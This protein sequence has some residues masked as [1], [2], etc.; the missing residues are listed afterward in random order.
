MSD[1]VVVVRVPSILVSV[2][3]P[4]PVVIVRTGIQ[5][6]QG[7]DG[8]DA[9]VH[10]RRYEKNGNY[11]YVATAPAGSLEAS[12]VWRVTRITYVAGVQTASGVSTNSS[13]TGRSGHTYV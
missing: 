8:E 1:P 4:A 11:I 5:G 3:V 12:A 6:N 7:E 13:W 10:S 2:S 9:S